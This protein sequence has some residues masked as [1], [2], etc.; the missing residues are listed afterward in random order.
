MCS[1]LAID[2][3]LADLADRQYGVVA[4]WQL[5][6]RGA[7]PDAIDLRLRRRRLRRLHRGVYAVGHVALRR[8]GAWLAAVLALGP[9]E[10]HLSHDSA[11]ALWGLTG[12]T[13]GRI[14]V[15]VGDGGRRRPELRLHH[16]GSSSARSA[17]P[18]CCGSS[19]SRRCERS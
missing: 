17:R 10:A 12:P 6:A 19:T 13:G 2:S 1:Q 4:R 8:E 9:A 5:L 16:R 14:D 3:L 11:A 7:S 18:R 15:M